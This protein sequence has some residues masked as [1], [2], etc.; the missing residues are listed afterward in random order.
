MVGRRRAV[1]SLSAGVV[2]LV[3]LVGLSWELQPGQVDFPTL[4]LYCLLIA[5]T[6]IFGIPLGGGVVSLDPMTALAAYL[7]MGLIPA[8]WAGFIGSFAYGLVR[9]IFAERLGLRP[10]PTRFEALGLA[11]AN[12]AI[13]SVCVLAAGGIYQVLGGAAPL[14]GVGLSDVPKLLA[15]DL[16]YLLTNYVWVGLYILTRGWSAFRVY[17]RSLARAVAYEG[18]PM[19][20]APLM[21]LV[22]TRIGL[23]SLALFALIFIVAS[24]IAHSL[25]R[26]GARLERR[27]KELTSLQVVGQ[28]LGASLN[29]DAIL[30]AIY[31]QVSQLMPAENFYVALYEAESDMVTFPLA[32]E[33]GQQKR[34]RPRQAGNGLTEYVLRTRSRVL[35]RDHLTETL[36]RLGVQAI[37]RAA[38]S[39]LGVPILAGEQPL[40]VIA[41]Q[42]CWAGE[43]YDESHKEILATIAGQA[44]V[45]IQNAR[46][47]ARTDA[48]LARRV[49]E[50]DS[51]LA[52]T[53]E[54][55]LLLDLD[56][57]VVAVNR[58]LANFARMTQL[59]L[60]GNLLTLTLPDGGTIIDRI[61]YTPAAL[62]ADCQHLSDGLAEVTE[63]SLQLLG[64]PPRFIV[65]TLT[66]VRDRQGAITGWLLVFRDQTEEIELERLKEDMV[67]VM[68]HD[69]RAPLTTLMSSLAMVHEVIGNHPD[70]EI[71]NLVTLAQR[72]G[73]R[74]LGLINRLL[75]INKL[76]SG[77]MPV[78]LALL[79]VQTL[80]DEV[81]SQFA[82]L[83]AETRIRLDVQIAA[84]LPQVMA[85]A[86]QIGRV[87]GNLIDNAIKFTPDQGQIRLWARVDVQHTSPA[88]A[89]GVSDSGSGVPQEAQP[90]LFKKF[91]SFSSPNS[92][93][94]G[95]GLGLFYCKLVV[96]AHG[97]EIWVESQP[98]QGSTFVF[99]LPLRENV[100]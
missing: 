42:S 7:S 37:G 48:A 78:H 36:A 45:A 44:A 20:F 39:Y 64:P 49:Q 10:E 25:A 31:H 15:L 95:T 85:D 58:A 14:A 99:R 93:R 28:A 29:Q 32:F 4:G 46:L 69:L 21:A 51:I 23:A 61:G 11:A 35:I 57:Q 62:Q 68:V 94:R 81:A 47:Y 83:L 80:F 66:P 70:Q 26:A 72:G 89:I 18:G 13:Q 84:D 41:V 40:G 27:V 73:N 2:V 59:E 92:R 97:G 34:W 6:A 9:Q 91:Q 38:V 96:E 52:T 30:S 22:S 79:D 19:V 63:R 8:G 24:L 67:H 16:A 33:E 3:F 76:E 100:L 88:L 12:A 65:R 17:L 87:L 71:T 86:E 55:V 1:V 5:F 77:K 43:L 74:M 53:A 54:G 90:H 60:H 98:G 50:L 56:H 75:D 82:P